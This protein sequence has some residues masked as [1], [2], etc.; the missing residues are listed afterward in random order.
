LPPFWWVRLD[1]AVRVGR[2]WFTSMPRPFS[3]M[4]AKSLA[5]ELATA[6]LATGDAKGA[7]ATA[8]SMIREDPDG[9]GGWWGRELLGSAAK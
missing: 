5:R 6:Q 7:V 1:D 4:Y 3:A 2:A 8:E 9:V